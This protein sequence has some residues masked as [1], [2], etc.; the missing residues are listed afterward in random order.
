MEEDF[1]EDSFRQRSDPDN[2]V[3]YTYRGDR[4]TAN[5][6][7]NKRLNDFFDNVDRLPELSVDFSRQRIA[8]SPF[9]YAGTTSGGYLE[10]LYARGSGNEDYSAFRFD[11]AHTVY[12][13]EKYFGFLTVIP[14]A[15]YRAT[16]YSKTFDS[17]TSTRV[18]TSSATNTVVSGGVTSRVVT[19]TTSTNSVTTRVARGSDVRS[20]PELG[21][22]TSF[23]AF[24]LW[25]GGAVSP[26]RHIVEPYADYTLVPE[27]SLTP[28]HIYQFDDIDKLGK[29]NN[30]QLGVRNKFQTKR[31]EN[32][33]NLI[34]VNLYTY[35][36]FRD[37]SADNEKGLD[38]FF[39]RALF[40]PN[41][42]VT[43]DTHLRYDTD[44]SELHTFNT[45]L[46][47]DRSPFWESSTEYRYTVDDSSLLSEDVTL[48]PNRQWA[49]NVF[50]RHEFE[51]SHT[52][53]IGGY[54]QRNLDCMSIRA[55]ATVEPS[56]TRSDGTRSDTEWGVILE[57]WLT[58]FPDIGVGRH[59]H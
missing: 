4:Y 47:V 18:A 57:L 12:Y 31:E 53:E 6:S 37:E 8:D 32:A 48:Y 29:Q 46:I 13:P 51:N 20:L 17:V 52:E 25:E 35:Y 26:L 39:A 14:R 1:F 10:K 50:G 49:V 56:Y 42:Q 15:G 19:V 30:V 44:N 33:W 23:K 5:V 43:V 22:E 11:T 41:K 2:H 40:T 59:R 45:R 28:D 34:D 9:Y 16:Y 27:P 3:V 7:A 55:G 21:F 24:K 54:L 38:D 36:R 58:A